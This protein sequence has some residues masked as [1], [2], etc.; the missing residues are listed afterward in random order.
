[1]TVLGNLTMALPELGKELAI[2]IEDELPYGSAGFVSRGR[3]V[4][5]QINNQK[6]LR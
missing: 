6:S 2:L 4:L 1:M 5:K 3:K